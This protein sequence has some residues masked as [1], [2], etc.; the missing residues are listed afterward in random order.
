MVIKRSQ[1][2]LDAF[3]K[4]KDL[5][6]TNKDGRVDKQEFYTRREE[7]AP[8]IKSFTKGAFHIVTHSDYEYWTSKY[9]PD[10]AASFWTPKIKTDDT[11][12]VFDMR[13]EVR[14]AYEDGQ[15]LDMALALEDQADMPK[16]LEALDRLEREWLQFY[17]QRQEEHQGL[18]TEAIKEKLASKCRDFV[19]EDSEKKPKEFLDQGPLGAHL[20]NLLVLADL[21]DFLD[22]E[23][24]HRYVADSSTA[25]LLIRGK[26]DCNIIATAALHLL[27]HVGR[28]AGIKAMLLNTDRGLH[29]TVA[30]K[31][32]PG[33][34]A[35]I[36]FDNA[37]EFIPPDCPNFYKDQFLE[38]FEIL[39]VN[40][41][42]RTNRINPS[43]KEWVGSFKQ[44]LAIN[45][46]DHV[47]SGSLGQRLSELGNKA[48]AITYLEQALKVDPNNP[49]NLMALGYLYLSSREYPRAQTNFR[50]ALDAATKKTKHQ[51]EGELNAKIGLL[52]SLVVTEEGTAL[53]AVTD[54]IKNKNKFYSH[55]QGYSYTQLSLY[56]ANALLGLGEYDKAQTY[57][58]LAHKNRDQLNDPEKISLFLGLGNVSNVRFD[59]EGALEWIQKAYA[60][61]AKDH[62]VLLGMAG[63]YHSQGKY[64]EAKEYYRAVLKQNPGD[65]YALSG[66]CTLAMQTG[67]Y[68][69]SEGYCRTLL[70]I[71]PYN[72]AAMTNLG[73]MELIRGDLDKAQSHLEEAL[74]LDPCDAV[75]LYFLGAVSSKQNKIETA[76]SYY[77]QSLKY[78]PENVGAML[79][80]AEIYFESGRYDEA[81]PLYEQAE[82]IA[83]HLGILGNHLTIY[84][85]TGRGDEALQ[86]VQNAI[87]NDG[88]TPN[89]LYNL[90]RVETLRNKYTAA[91]AAYQKILEN[92]PRDDTAL[93]CL[94]SIQTARGDFKG[95]QQLLEAAYKINPNNPYVYHTS[96]ILSYEQ[97]DYEGAL[98]QIS[99][100]QEINPQDTYAMYA[101]YISAYYLTMLER[102]DEAI[103]VGAELLNLNPKSTEALEV[104]YM[105]HRASDN[106]TE[107]LEQAAAIEKINPPYTNHYTGAGEFF[108]RKKMY[109]EAVKEFEAALR[110]NEGDV[111]ALAGLG[112]T[113]KAMGDYKNAGIAF[114]ALFE[115]DPEN[116]YAQ[117]FLEQQKK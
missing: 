109:K 117:E 65:E 84:E 43:T 66:L 74:K 81:L 17:E 85:Q 54:G 46:R 33:D 36:Y 63:V 105:A 25:D 27:K 3:N 14:I 64:K 107:A 40:V 62:N 52:C 55:G 78:S 68:T 4:T 8:Q 23:K 19:W 58:Q 114:A 47:A 6:D 91:T 26:W 83:P 53:S 2:D 115:L 29:G 1:T 102:V 59:P 90:A 31:F 57:Y 112:R 99:R 87:K 50:L 42:E 60:I 82:K 96:A 113:Y 92:N 67:D 110:K 34:K 18:S 97:E 88:E 80:L 51:H 72:R 28:A 13:D 95:A 30:Y 73:Q 75:V 106:L 89:L 103:A 45:P 77:Q 7:I 16:A 61:N 12:D 48:E 41:Q 94:A 116:V 20:N 10:T 93:L 15:L 100:A 108:R 37:F 101:M 11:T 32:G 76:I 39:S 86:V 79:A 69:A 44:M 38:P 70:Q 98:T 56:V 71:N 21:I 9:K 35:F 49:D 22:V 111:S 104:L 24:K 5:L